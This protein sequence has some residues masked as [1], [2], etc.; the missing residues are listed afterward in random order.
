[1]QKNFEHD[2][3]IVLTSL[4]LTANASLA[5]NTPSETLDALD[6][7]ISRMQGLKRKMEALHQEEKLLHQHSKKRLQHLQDLYEIPSL[8][9]VKYDEWSRLRLNRLLVDYLLRCGYGE[10]ARALAKEKNIEDL[11]DL[12]VFIQCHKI[13][14]SLKNRQTQE[15]LLW[16]IENRPMMRKAATH[17]STVQS[18]N[19]VFTT[20]TT[21]LTAQP[22]VRTTTTTIHR[23]PQR[24]P[25]PR[26][27]TACPETHG[28]APIHPVNRD[29]SSGRNPRLSSRHSDRTIQGTSYHAETPQNNF[30]P[31]NLTISRPCTP[32]HDGTLSPP[33]S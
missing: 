1:M 20:L 9:D 23:A 21:V 25:A 22:R 18:Q 12:D 2:R 33:S 16:C 32:S 8:A 24:R 15:C 14:E 10:S 19:Y 13:E 7:M 30:P 26:S 17:V 28:S 27:Q 29:P 4:K 3:G 5:G 31:Q 6:I 11:V